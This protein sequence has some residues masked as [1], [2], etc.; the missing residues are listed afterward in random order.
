M[1]SRHCYLYFALLTDLKYTLSCSL[2]KKI[3]KK[4][5]FFYKCVLLLILFEKCLDRL[6]VKACDLIPKAEPTGKASD[7][8]DKFISPPEVFIKCRYFFV[9]L[10]FTTSC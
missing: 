6:P 4:R 5:L 1:F 3:R 10:S 7:K 8:T 9:P 2:V